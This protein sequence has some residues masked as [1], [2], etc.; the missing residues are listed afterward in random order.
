MSGVLTRAER[1][2]R[3]RE[4]RGR[5]PL[6]AEADPRVM[7][8]PA[9]GNR[10]LWAAP[11]AG[12][13]AGAGLFRRAPWGTSP[14]APWIPASGVQNCERPQPCAVSQRLSQSHSPLWQIQEIN[15]GSY[16][17]AFFKN[18]QSNILGG[19]EAKCKHPPAP[20]CTLPLQAI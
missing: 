1:D 8:V 20:P 13:E 11:P 18:L 4:R 15:T 12:R 2:L 5:G 10:G 9:S 3:H 7:R 14:D 19:K 16:Q 17:K 6:K